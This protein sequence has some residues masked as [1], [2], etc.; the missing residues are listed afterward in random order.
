MTIQTVSGITSG[1]TEDGRVRYASCNDGPM[2][3][4]RW[5]WRGTYPDADGHHRESSERV[6]PADWAAASALMAAV[7]AAH[8]AYGDRLTAEADETL[9][10][11]ADA[12][13]DSPAFWRAIRGDA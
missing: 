10:R 13:P 9:Q 2:I 7:D 4:G 3:D 1:S 5:A 6:A 11:R 12:I 8:R